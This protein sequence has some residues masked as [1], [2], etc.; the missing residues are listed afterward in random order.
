MFYDESIDKTYADMMAE[1]ILGV[2]QVCYLYTPIANFSTV[3]TI[4][5]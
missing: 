3:D 5:L 1:E 4:R 2:Y